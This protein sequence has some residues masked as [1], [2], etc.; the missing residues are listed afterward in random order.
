MTRKMT[1]ST[2]HTQA[3]QGLIELVVAIGIIMI[4]LMGVVGL[5]LSNYSGEQSAKA[6]IVGANLA[7]EGV[8]LVRN[9]RDT[10]WLFIDENMFCEGSSCQWY[11]GLNAGEYIVVSDFD[12]ILDNN[13][14]LN[15]DV[16]DTTLYINEN[17]FY[18]H[19]SSG[20]PTLYHRVVTIRDICCNDADD[21]LQCNNI[22]DF[23]IKDENTTCK[24]NELLV[25]KDIESKVSWTL[26]DRDQEVVIQSQL[27]N[28]R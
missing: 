28:W 12:N 13:V 19:N 18:S 22:G 7:R 27:F 16:S 1:T 24:S 14:Y 2:N 6:R 11:S 20:K 21:D 5:F 25:G 8:E 10:N 23:D 26:A 3:G 9:I 15:S 4:V 17:G